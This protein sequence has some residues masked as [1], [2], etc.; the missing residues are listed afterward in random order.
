M[1]YK[2][3]RQKLLNKLG[4]GLLLLPTSKESLRNGDVHHEY[5]ASSDLLYLSG[6][7][8]PEA[9]LLAWRLSS[10]AHRCILFV[11]PSDREREIWEGRRIG[12]RGAV[13]DYG[14]DEAYSIGEFWQRLPELLAPHARLFCTLGR[15]DAFDQGLFK[16]FKSLEMKNRRRAAAAHPQLIDPRPVI[17]ELRLIKDA[18]EIDALERA[19]KISAAAHLHAMQVARPGMTEY[20]VQAALEER[21][22]TEGS[23]RNGYPSIVASGNNA[24]I[25]HYTENRRKMTGRDLLLLDAGA[26]VDHYT[27]DITRTWPVSGRFTAP[28]RAVYRVVLAAQR[29]ALRMVQPGKPCNAP[30]RSAQ[31]AITKGLVEL[32]VLKGKPQNLM[33]THAYKPW[34]MHG[35]SH[36]LGMDVHDVGA[37]EDSR[38]RPI[39][40]RA[41]MALTIE[42]GLYFDARDQRVP[43]ELRGIGVR[44]ED[45][46]LVTRSGHRV[47]TSDVPKETREVEAACLNG[48]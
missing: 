22:R 9:L 41:G 2:N 3:R 40:L 36:W 23:A 7:P 24:C 4:D 20:Q 30:H 11:Q 16:V 18:E 46:V 42:P 26:E 15:D 12:I 31:R 8:Q 17:A 14:A 43:K 47:L 29:A 25:L 28:Q 27:A 19:G 34:F 6:F 13:R 33:A 1:S 5:R 45:D 32:G 21:F 48:S 38:G 10:K 39:G 37:Y 44:I 35:T